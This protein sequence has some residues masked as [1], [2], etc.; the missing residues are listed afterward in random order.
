MR[1]YL[2]FIGWVLLSQMGFG[3]QVDPDLLMAKERLDAIASFNA[4]LN[5]TVDISFVNMPTQVSEDELS[6]RRTHYFFF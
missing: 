2:I 5:L 3:Q 1:V 6:E 4:D